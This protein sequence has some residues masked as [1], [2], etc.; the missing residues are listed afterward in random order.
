MVLRRGTGGSNGSPMK[1]KVKKCPN[2]WP[3]RTFQPILVMVFQ[4]LRQL[5]RRGAEWG[6]SVSRTRWTPLSGG[7]SRKPS[8]WQESSS[9]G[10]SIQQLT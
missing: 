8:D 10:R 6:F 3:V 9:T 4:C 2:L 5:H 7:C 1:R